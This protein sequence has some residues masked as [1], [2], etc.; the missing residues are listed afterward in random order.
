MKLLFDFGLLILIWLVQL[1]IYPSFEYIDKTRLSIWHEKYT[2]L[3][4]IVVMPLMIGQ[5]ILHASALWRSVNTLAMLQAVFIAL[6][7]IV[8]FFRAVPLHNQLQQAIS[9]D[10]TIIA[11]IHWNWPRTILWSLVFIGSLL[12]W[13]KVF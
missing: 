6:C 8:T 7:W 12:E 1:I 4:T 11:L 3:I 10:K 5:V 9:V 2:V 13:K